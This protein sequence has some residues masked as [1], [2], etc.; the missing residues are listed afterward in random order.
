MFAH[1]K[2]KICDRKLLHI[3]IM[4]FQDYTHILDLLS[5]T[6]KLCSCELVPYLCKETTTIHLTHV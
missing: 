6:K 2:K 1:C 4:P 5:E 3:E